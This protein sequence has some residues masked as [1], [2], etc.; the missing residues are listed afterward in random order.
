MNCP[1][2]NAAEWFALAMLDISLEARQK[3]IPSKLAV[4]VTLKLGSETGMLEAQFSAARRDGPQFKRHSRVGP[5]RQACML[6]ACPLQEARWTSFIDAQPDLLVQSFEA[7]DHFAAFGARATHKRA[8]PAL[9]SLGGRNGI[10][11][12][13]ARSR[14]LNQPGEACLDFSGLFT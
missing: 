13:F 10:E 11:S 5:V 8:P 9:D 1:L 4:G 3:T 14:Q 6:D 7:E 12:V 2:W